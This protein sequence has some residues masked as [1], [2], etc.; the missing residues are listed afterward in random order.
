M[1]EPRN[2]CLEAKGTGNGITQP[3]PSAQGGTQ[4]KPETPRSENKPSDSKTGTWF[5]NFKEVITAIIAITIIVPTVVLLWQSLYPTVNTTNA[6]GIFAILGGWGGVI[7]GYYFGRVPAEKAADKASEAADTARKERDNAVR[8][9][10]N[11]E[12]GKKQAQADKKRSLLEQKNS[13]VALRKQF[14][15]VAFAAKGGAPDLVEKIN[16]LIEKIDND[17][18]ATD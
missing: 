2:P 6:Q 18:L 9:R 7:L 14:T 3:S 11:A 12:A 16:S 4:T 1:R 8:D 17:M 13:L 15:G 5:S 10:A